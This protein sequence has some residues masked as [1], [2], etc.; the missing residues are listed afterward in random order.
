[1]FPSFGSV[2]RYENYPES[3]YTITHH[4]TSKLYT[5]WILFLL[6]RRWYVLVLHIVVTSI[7]IAIPL[8]LIPMKCCIASC[9]LFTVMWWRL[10]TWQLIALA[11]SENMKYKSK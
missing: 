5:D 10:H 8:F 7:W 6:F 9:L 1:V 3:S 11:F 4:A 2:V